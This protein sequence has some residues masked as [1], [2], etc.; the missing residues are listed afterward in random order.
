[1]PIVK[2]ALLY[3]G[4]ASIV[5]GSIDQLSMKMPP[6]PKPAMIAMAKRTMYVFK[7]KTVIN[8]PRAKIIF[9]VWD[10]IFFRFL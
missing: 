10:T 8:I 7:P 4:S 9:A 6:M 3:P 5:S 2:C 1:M